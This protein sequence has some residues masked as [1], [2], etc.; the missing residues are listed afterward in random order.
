MGAQQK[1]RMNVDPERE[2]TEEML[3]TGGEDDR[4]M[5][6]KSNVSCG[7]ATELYCVVV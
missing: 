6:K 3:A 5:W 1:I 7:W 2:K 4:E